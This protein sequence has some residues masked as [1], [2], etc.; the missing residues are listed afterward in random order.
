VLLFLQQPAKASTFQPVFNR[1]NLRSILKSAFVLFFVLIYGISIGSGAKKDAYQ[2]PT[3]KGLKEAKGLYNVSSFVINRDTIPYSLS[4]STRW[5]NVVFE[6]WNTLSILTNLP[7]PLDSNNEHIVSASTANRLYE[8]EGTNGRHYYSYTVDEAAAVL[9]LQNRF[10]GAAND[11]FSLHYT[12]PDSSTILLNGIT[13]ANDTI[14][15]VLN[16][17]EK[18]YLLEEASGKSRNRKIKL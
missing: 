10:P 11:K 7:A 3:Q 13:A 9:Q 14:S 18:K 15:I 4:D 6:E 8:I 17:I 12:R 5:R 2:Y 1:R 16:K